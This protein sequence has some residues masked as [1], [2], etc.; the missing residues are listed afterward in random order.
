MQEALTLSNNSALVRA[1]MGF[2]CAMAGWKDEALEIVGEL[3]ELAKEKY[4]SAY[5]FARIFAGLG[6]ADAV[7]TWLDRALEERTVFFIHCP[8]SVDPAFRKVSSDPRF[9][10]VLGRIGLK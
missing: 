9:S 8:I 5:S 4:V 1:T 3:E 6:N 2:T 7:F 10:E